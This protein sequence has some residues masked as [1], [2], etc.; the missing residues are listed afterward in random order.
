[1][2]R[3]TL[4]R[5][6]TA[7]NIGALTFPLVPVTAGQAY[8]FSAYLRRDYATSRSISL[9][10]IFFN[11][12]GGSSG[13]TQQIVITP[14][15]INT[16]GRGSL[17]FTP[18]ATTTNVRVD[19]LVQTPIVGETIYMDGFLLETGSSLLPYFDGTNAGTY[20]GYTLTEQ[21]WN[22]TANAS[23]S[24]ATWGLTSTFIGSP[25]DDEDFAVA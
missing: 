16:W 12:T 9:R 10:A 7:G 23:T 4:A 2:T 14:P 3:L 5:T 1:M 22:G 17:T 8:T 18:P 21:A 15:A 24:T 20:T 11:S 6:S 19:V 25:L 13:T